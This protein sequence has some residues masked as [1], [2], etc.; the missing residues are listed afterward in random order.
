MSTLKN[1]FL[2]QTSSMI[3]STI[4]KQRTIMSSIFFFTVVLLF[5]VSLAQSDLESEQRC[6]KSAPYSCE[7]EETLFPEDEQLTIKYAN[8]TISNIEYN[9]KYVDFDINYDDKSTLIRLVACGCSVP[10]E[11]RNLVYTNPTNIFVEDGPAL[12]MFTEIFDEGEDLPVK[13]VKDSQYI[14]NE[15]IINLINSNPPKIYSTYS[16]GT[17]FNETLFN[18]FDDVG[19]GLISSL[20]FES[21]G[22][23]NTE[24]FFTEMGRPIL[25]VAELNEISPLARAE[26]MKII[27][28]LYNRTAKASQIF[29][30][31]EKE[32]EEAKDL[33]SKAN[34][35]PSVFFNYPR[36]P[37]PANSFTDLRRFVWTQPGFGQYIV[38][39]IRDANADYRY[40]FKG[41]EDSGN[42]LFFPQV[43]EEFTSARFLLNS[44]PFPYRNHTIEAFINDTVSVPTPDPS[45]LQSMKSFHAVRCG[46]VWGRRNRET[47]S[48]GLDFFES[49]VARPDILL[50]DYVKILHPDVNLGDHIVFYMKQYQDPEGADLTCPYVSLLTDPPSGSIYVDKSISI[51]GL[52]R[53]Q[54]QDQ[55]VDNV[56]PELSKRSIS[57]DK[58]DVQF[59]EESKKNESS[60]NIVVRL[61][62]STE[63]KQ[64]VE[65]SSNV[66]DAF[67]EG[68]RGDGT[69]SVQEDDSD[70]LS[71]LPPPGS[72]SNDSSSSNELSP[73]VIAV[74]VLSVCL[75][76]MILILVVRRFRK[77]QNYEEQ[78]NGD[79]SLA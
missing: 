58:M 38:Q 34:R 40:Y 74:I 70:T 52:D 5:C 42:E 14:Y 53:F 1:S 50:K 78:W 13:Y 69:I 68:L 36:S 37:F 60:V 39:F 44:D 25:P 55:L 48:G 43:E 17:G 15:R 79:S 76:L 20:Q 10:S 11:G 26:W 59:R 30:E 73:G 8:R 2:H 64:D 45:Y 18:Q 24:Q 35:R 32:Y 54:V 61:L 71:E 12:Y 72:S 77:K 47:D 22:S 21:P 33:A 63:D 56:Y 62:V 66:T 29:D 4:T 49:G 7:T 51:D 3:F 57:L 16:F 19:M 31:I 27:G 65:K 9:N 6:Q 46:A 75:V 28:L 67:K 23:K 41:E